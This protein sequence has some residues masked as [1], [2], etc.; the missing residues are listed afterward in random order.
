MTIFYAP[1]N[2]E[3]AG[4]IHATKIPMAKF[5]LAGFYGSCNGLMYRT[6]KY[7]VNIMV[8]NPLRS[9]FKILPPLHIE[10][11]G[12]LNS[13]Y[14]TIGLGFDGLTKTF[15]IVRSYKRPSSSYCTLVHTL[16]TTSWREVS[17]VTADYYHDNKSV[18][19]HGFLHWRTNI[20]FVI[21]DCVGRTL[22]FDVS[23]ETFKVIPFPQIDFEKDRLLRIF[24]IKGNLAMLDLLRGSKIDI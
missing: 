24:D 2:I 17:S 7:R 23:K 20:P 16:G 5:Q 22:V 21:K 1:C 18:F 6:D 11:Y 8:S 12:H 14:T 19:V 4:V 10:M 9:R 15:K 3:E 13:D